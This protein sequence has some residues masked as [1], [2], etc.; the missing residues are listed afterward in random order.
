MEFQ[1]PEE[2][3][4]GGGG[5]KGAHNLRFPHPATHLVVGPSASGKTWRTA[6]ILRLKDHLFEGGEDVQN[7]VFCYALWQKEYDRLRSE[8]VVTRWV[9]KLPT[10]EEFIDLVRPF[11]HRGGSIVV[12]DDFMTDINKD[13]VNIVTKT[14][15]HTNTSTFILFQSLFPSERL[16][17][18]ISL[19]IKFMHI[20]K[21][22]RENAQIQYLARQLSPVSY[23]WIVQAYHRAT[24]RPYSCFLIDMTQGARKY[25]RYR[26]NYLPNEF[27]MLVWQEKS[28]G[29]ALAG[30]ID[31]ISSEDG[32]P[33]EAWPWRELEK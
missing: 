7:V 33:L 26:S 21:N 22:P 9:N 24:E 30:G 20:H 6:Q 16:G 3:A 29:S 18:Q 8:G 12:I 32:A 11:Q 10:E 5:A 15:G 31:S 13:L 2:R 28:S 1:G 23:K 25:L 27:P 4:I 19:N 17:R 14:S